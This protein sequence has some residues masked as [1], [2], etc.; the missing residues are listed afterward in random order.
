MSND[1]DMFIQ[2]QSEIMYYKSIS[3]VINSFE[4]LYL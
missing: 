2:K 3:D 4:N 1:F